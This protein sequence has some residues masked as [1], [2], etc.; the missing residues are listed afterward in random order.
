MAEETK[1]TKKIVPWKRNK[2]KKEKKKNKKKRRKIL[3]VISV[4]FLLLVVICWFAFGRKVMQLRS[5]AKEIVE[6]ST[7]DT[8]KSSQTSVV[9]DT[10]G[11]ELTKFKGEKDAYYLDY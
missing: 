10:N 8:F 7:V 5:E 9:Y 2:K 4:I 11:D 3:A 6:E 1:E